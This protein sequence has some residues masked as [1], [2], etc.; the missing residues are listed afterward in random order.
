[1][2]PG[3][4][5]LTFFCHPLKTLYTFQRSSK[6]FSYWIFPCCC[7]P[8]KTFSRV[9]QGFQ[10]ADLLGLAFYCHI[11]RTLPTLK[12]GKMGHAIVRVTS[13]DPVDPTLQL[14]ATF[15]N[16]LQENHD[17]SR[18]GGCI[19]LMPRS[20]Q[21]WVSRF[22]HCS[23]RPSLAARDARVGFGIGKR[24]RLHAG[25]IGISW[26]YLYRRWRTELIV[27]HETINTWRARRKSLQDWSSE[28]QPCDRW[29]CLFHF[30]SYQWKLTRL[31]NARVSSK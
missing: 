27:C 10:R 9:G 13:H 20:P 30:I 25:K 18:L 19:S 2:V 21:D 29:R 15:C 28:N 16:F 14:S 11:L 26:S 4:R 7:H 23:S 31:R 24:H 12:N 5:G 3:Y 17:L 22:R 8:L 1:M 6:N